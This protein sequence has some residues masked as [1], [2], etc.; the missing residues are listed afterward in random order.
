MKTPSTKI[1][2]H[3]KSFILFLFM[4]QVAT[5]LNDMLCAFFTQYF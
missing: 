3:T 2:H 1:L 5:W 4:F